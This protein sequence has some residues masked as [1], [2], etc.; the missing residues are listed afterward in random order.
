MIYP[1][2]L[3]SDCFQANFQVG[4]RIENDS[5]FPTSFHTEI[6]IYPVNLGHRH[7]HDIIK[8]YLFTWFDETQCFYHF[9]NQL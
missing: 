8:E 4:D 1:M 5:C 3:N 6:D 7:D 2:F 9:Q